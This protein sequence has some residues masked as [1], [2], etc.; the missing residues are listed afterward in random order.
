MYDRAGQL[1]GGTLGSASTSGTRPRIPRAKIVGYINDMKKL[2][3]SSATIPGQRGGATPCRP[4]P[5]IEGELDHARFEARHDER[6]HELPDENVVQVVGNCPQK[7]SVVTSA[8]I[9]RKWRGTKAA[10]RFA[11]PPVEVRNMRVQ[12]RMG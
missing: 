5:Q 11:G 12:H 9:S 6:L 8:K 4:V 2:V 3:S 10:S 1:Y 7:N